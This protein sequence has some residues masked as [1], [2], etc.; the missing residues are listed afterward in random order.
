MKFLNR[1]TKYNESIKHLLKPKSDELLRKELEKIRGIDRVDKALSLGL[2]HL[3]TE[4]DILRDIEYLNDWKKFKLACKHNLLWLVKHLLKNDKDGNIYVIKLGYSIA[5]RS[6]SKEVYTF[7]DKYI[8]SEMDDRNKMLNESIT[9]FLKPK[10][11]DDIINNINNLEDGK[12]WAYIIKYD[13]KNMFSSDEL[14]KYRLNFKKYIDD[15]LNKIY[16]KIYDRLN[17]EIGDRLYYRHNVKSLLADFYNSIISYLVFYDNSDKFIN[18]IID[19]V[20]K[21]IKRSKTHNESIRH[22]LKPK[23]EEDVLKE[24]EKLSDSDKIIKIIKYN[25]PHELLPDNL[26]V[27]GSLDCSNNQ[28]TK[29]PDNLT[30]KGNLYCSGNQLTKLP[31]NLTV[32]GGL[33]CS[34]NQLTKLPDNLTV[35]GDLYCSNNQLSRNTKKPKGVKGELYL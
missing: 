9:H 34:Y 13:L 2:K 7:L 31:D 11:Q 33:Y 4:E 10:N 18:L 5:I 17:D 32:K 25:L 22:L 26:T 20:I 8:K 24:L 15:S 6:N 3:L 35:N 1:Y 28:L 30:V 16:D 12:K 21:Q 23:N 27:Q 29:L 19:H 14:N